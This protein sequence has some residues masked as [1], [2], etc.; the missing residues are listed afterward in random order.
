MAAKRRKRLKTMHLYYLD[1]AETGEKPEFTPK[2][3]V[4]AWCEQNKHHLF[5]SDTSHPKLASSRT[6]SGQ[7]ER[8][9]Q[10]LQ[11][12]SRPDKRQSPGR[13]AGGDRDR[14][15]LG[16]PARR[17]SAERP[18]AARGVCGV[19]VAFGGAAPFAG[20][21]FFA[22]LLADARRFGPA[23]GLLRGAHTGGDQ[24]DFGNALFI[25]ESTG[26]FIFDY[27]LYERGAPP[28]RGKTGREPGAAAGFPDRPTD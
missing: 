3:S 12:G 6:N 20:A 25:S 13:L 15:R 14:L 9:L 8:G 18:R 7:I 23:G 22:G 10:P 26:G 1:G 11:G 16:G 27:K 19:R 17:R 21:S 28:R 4:I 24:V 5:D 2:K